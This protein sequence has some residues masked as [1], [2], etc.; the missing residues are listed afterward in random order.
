MRCFSILDHVLTQVN[1]A[2]TTLF[3]AS[4]DVRENP[5]KSQPDVVLSEEERRISEGCMRVNHTGEVCA[6]ALYRG[7]LLCSQN[8]T[9]REMLQ[10][11]CDEETDHLSWTQ[12]RLD[13]LN[14]R[15]SYINAFWY[16]NS[17]FIGVVAGMAG[18][19][20]SLGFVEETEKQVD[21]HLQ[22][23]LQKMPAKDLKSRAIIDQM[24]EDELSHASAA[25]DAGASPLPAFIKQLMQIQA[26]IMTTSTYYI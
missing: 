21:R 23:H 19:K 24:R 3:V 11:S 8:E 26:K 14:G 15:T 6:Q 22:S 17:F 9:T 16:L 7:Q 13:E 1:H 20:W 12:A 25:L 4:A 5:A 10:H 2:M 18:D